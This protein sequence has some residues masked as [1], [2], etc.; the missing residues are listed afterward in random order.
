MDRLT[1]AAHLVDSLAWPI[2][3]LLAAAVFRDPI[4]SV[5]RLLVK[6]KYGALELTF[7]EEVDKLAE[8]T[9]IAR[10]APA[11]DSP[12]A[13]DQELLQLAELSPATAVI[14]AWRQIETKL[15]ELGR[16]KLDEPSPALWS[17]PAVLTATLYDRDLLTAEEYAVASE[18]RRLRNR[19]ANP[20]VDREHV[21]EPDARRYVTTALGLIAR[22]AR[23]TAASVPEPS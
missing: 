10:G 1:F 18:L 23:G 3:V 11:L 4:A 9:G 8:Q 16:A 13:R 15:I 2:T 22:L 12:S 17:M 5:L 19:V 21:G 7:R 6:L 20:G 14:E